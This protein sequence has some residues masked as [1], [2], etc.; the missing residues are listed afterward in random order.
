MKFNK[1]DK[2]L[3]RISRDQVRGC[4]TWK[5]NKTTDGYAT[6]FLSNGVRGNREYH[7]KLVGRTIYEYFMGDV[8]PGLI[9]V[10]T[11]RNRACVNPAHLKP[12]TYGEA[13]QQNVDKQKRTQRMR[14]VLGKITFEQAQEMR[15]LRT[16]RRYKYKHLSQI[17]GVGESTVCD[18]LANR[19]WKQL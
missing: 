5:G 9:L 10:R 1:I 8:K 11:C 12:G 16:E 19:A 14:E 4:W 7:R 18:V 17:F 15:K 6:F 13:L 2:I 3:E